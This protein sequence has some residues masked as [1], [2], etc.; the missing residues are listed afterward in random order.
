MNKHFPTLKIPVVGRPVA[1]ADARALAKRDKFQF[2][3]WATWLVGGPLGR[4]AE[5]RARQRSRRRAVL[6]DGTRQVR[7]RRDL[8]ER[9]GSYQSGEWCVTSR[10]PGSAKRQISG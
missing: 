8:C 3:L 2:Q 10:G 5:E 6:C 9:R 7:P 4:R 1:V